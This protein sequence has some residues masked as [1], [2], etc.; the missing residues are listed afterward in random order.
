MELARAVLEGGEARLD[1]GEVAASFVR[2]MCLRT[3]PT[4]T[5]VFIRDATITGE[6]LNLDALR[7]D[8]PLKLRGC[9]LA[10]IAIRDARLVTLDL[11]E[12]SCQSV[13]GDRAR[14]DHGL[15]MNN[16]FK[17]ADIV[18]LPS[19][20]VGDDVNCDGGSFHCPP[21]GGNNWAIMLDGAQIGGRLLMRWGA[22]TR[23]TANGAV[24]ADSTRIGGA[25]LCRG[26]HVT[27]RSGN[28]ALSFAAAD[29]R[30]RGHIWGAPRV[31]V[32]ESRL[33]FRC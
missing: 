14:I 28:N 19:A 9:T 5:Q 8:F 24:S 15:L 3:N 23:F 21:G 11:G 27:N 17:A 13:W 10:K 22:G 31:I 25:I 20:T 12:T 33:A 32:G 18:W 4:P 30:G 6:E 2:A 7:L 29:I 1:H 26:A 16:G